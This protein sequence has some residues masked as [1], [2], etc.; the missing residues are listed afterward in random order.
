LPHLFVIAHNLFP[1]R[2]SKSKKPHS[3]RITTEGLQQITK[4]LVLTVSLERWPKNT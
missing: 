4:N 1:S 2:S 3:G